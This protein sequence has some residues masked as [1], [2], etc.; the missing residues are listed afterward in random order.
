MNRNQ[1]GFDF[2]IIFL[3]FF[4][5]LINESR[6]SAFTIFINFIFAKSNLIFLIEITSTSPCLIKFF[7]VMFVRKN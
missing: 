6:L 4:K 7:I 1:K 2:S 5:L 3:F